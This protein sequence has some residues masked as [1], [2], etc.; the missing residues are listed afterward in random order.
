MTREDQ[1]TAI[2][3]KAAAAVAAV[4]TPE[5]LKTFWGMMKVQVDTE[6]FRNEVYYHLPAVQTVK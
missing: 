6:E 1:L 4:L 2:K 5:E 3:M